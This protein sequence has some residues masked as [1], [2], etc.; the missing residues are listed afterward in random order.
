MSLQDIRERKSCIP[1]ALLK[2]LLWPNSFENGQVRKTMGKTA[3][4]YENA[5]SSFKKKY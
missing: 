5:K 3:F 1:Q 2:H 4:P